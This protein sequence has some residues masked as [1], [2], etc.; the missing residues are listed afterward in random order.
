MTSPRDP[1]Q[2]SSQPPVP[3]RRRRTRALTADQVAQYTA[4]I[5]A[6]SSWRQVRALLEETGWAPALSEAAVRWSGWFWMTEGIRDQISGLAAQVA[7]DTARLWQQQ[8]ALRSVEPW[9][10]VARLWDVGFRGQ[11]AFG[12]SATQSLAPQMDLRLLLR[13]RLPDV[14]AAWLCSAWQWSTK[15]RSSITVG[16]W[17]RHLLTHPAATDELWALAVERVRDTRSMGRTML[18]RLMLPAHPGRRAEGTSLSTERRLLLRLST[19]AGQPLHPYEP[20]SVSRILRSPLLRGL[21]LDTPEPAGQSQGDQLLADL[22]LL[23]VLPGLSGTAFA[24]ALER[25]GPSLLRWTRPGAAS[26]A[27]LRVVDRRTPPTLL[28]LQYALRPAQLEAARDQLTPL[29]RTW[30]RAPERG[31]REFAIQMLGRHASVGDPGLSPSPTP[32]RR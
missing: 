23:H 2:S 31:L 6:A 8:P 32:T 12:L 9:P 24:T 18:L 30:I 20:L 29:W 10:Q 27:M 3:C 1:S 28:E 25:L 26:D 4:A 22:A 21:V 13:L 16:G 11:P 5:T 19:Q 17:E 15:A 14:D 7:F